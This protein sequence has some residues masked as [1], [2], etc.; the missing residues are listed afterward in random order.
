M[1]AEKDS[2]SKFDK[3]YDDWKNG[4]GDD[5]QAYKKMTKLEM[6]EFIE[7][8]ASL[9]SRHLIINRMRLVLEQC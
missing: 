7:F 8:C 1:K 6:L 2:R 3:I 5:G 4:N 9:E